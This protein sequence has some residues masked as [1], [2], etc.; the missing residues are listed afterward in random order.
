M[1][2]ATRLTG[3]TKPVVQ[4]ATA[5]GGATPP[6]ISSRPEQVRPLVQ[7]QSIEPLERPNTSCGPI[8]MVKSAVTPLLFVQL[9]NQSPVMTSAF[10]ASEPIPRT[11]AAAARN[12]R[13]LSCI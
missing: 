10:A 3:F 1:S 4:K 9:P 5:L 2:V 6:V 8:V 13:V 7:V 11:V 12:Q